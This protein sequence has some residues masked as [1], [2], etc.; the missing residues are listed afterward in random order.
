MKDNVFTKFDFFILSFILL[1]A[2]LFRLYKIN[3]PLA[4]LHSW[5]QTDTS[6][7]TRNF[8]R[9]GIDLFHPKYDDLSNV[10]SGIENPQGYRMV[11]FPIYNA[12]TAV[13]YGFF[14]FF[15]LEIWGRLTTIIFSLIIISIIYYLLLHESSRIS[16]IFGSL[17]YALFPFFVFF[18]RVILPETTALSFVMMSIFFLYLDVGHK[19]KGFKSIV[20]NLASSVFFACALLIK[21]TVIFYLLPILVLFYRKY[22]LSLIKKAGFYLYFFV[23]LA[24]LVYWRMYIKNFP[25]GIPY[26]DWLFTSV[27]TADG[28]KSILFRP[29]FFRWIF[30]ERFNNLILGGYTAL[31]F[32]L[33]II[34]KQKK[35]LL[36]SF[37]FS[38]LAY[39][40]VFQGGNLQHEYYQTLILPIF[41]MMI[42]LGIS[43]IYYHKKEFL[44]PVF[45]SFLIFS[46]LGLSFYFS[47]FKV[48]DYYVYSHELIQ[49]AK[50]INS[51]TAPEDKIVVDRTGD[52][53]LLYLADRRGAS[54]IFR[55]PIDLKILGYKYLM[56]SSEGQIEMMRPEF[57]IVFENEKFTLFRL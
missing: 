7:V 23:A 53:T 33:G 55:D 46:L 41:P 3:I 38:A 13:L 12:I 49:E 47:F 11:E 42:G 4:D 25:E 52:T 9:N 40:F 1:I 15:S 30:F 44:H 24:P 10:Q 37:V 32:V 48:K 54:S 45:V 28:L 8:V 18:S 14:P 20:Y 50:I 26:S 31:F 57:K 21:P 5:R 19:E 22:K 34:V 51:L 17:T 6:A 27:N 56:T 43:F 2:L 16:A 35:H 36:L 39:I 29:S